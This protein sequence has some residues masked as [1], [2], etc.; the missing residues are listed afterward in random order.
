M[1]TGVNR[2]KGQSWW[3][4]LLCSAE[5]DLLALPSVGMARYLSKRFLDHRLT[6]DLKD[7][8]EILS[9]RLAD[10]K[11]ELDERVNAAKAENDARLKT[12]VE[13]SA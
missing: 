4:L 11:A 2:P 5:W 6:K 9:K 12:D 1:L 7:Y 3:T 8:E 10:H 13:E